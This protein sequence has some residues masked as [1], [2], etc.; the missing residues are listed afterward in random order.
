MQIAWGDHQVANFTAFDEARTIGAAAVGGSA[1]SNTLGGGE[2]LLASRLCNT[3]SN[4]NHTSNDPVDGQYCYA[5]DSPLWN[6]PAISAYPYNGSAITIFDSGPDGSADHLGGSAATGTDPPPPSDVPP[7]DTSANGDPHGYPRK[8]CA[9][10]DQKGA[11]FD[12][13]GA[14][15]GLAGYV[16]APTQP[17]DAGGSL[18]GPPYFSGGWHGT[19]SQ[20]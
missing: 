20:A 4:G 19:C 12:V 11:F 17:L 10:Q 6:I 7:P 8:A 1:T 16:T 2:A 18:A 9:A 14:I 3:D 5:P 13:N 15:T